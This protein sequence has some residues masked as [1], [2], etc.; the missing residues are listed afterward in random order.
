ME[1][2]RGGR[3]KHCGATVVNGWRVLE[4]EGWKGADLEA[5]IRMRVIGTFGWR[6]TELL[7]P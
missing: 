4:L 7:Y 5:L 6:Y 1:I 2:G 3:W